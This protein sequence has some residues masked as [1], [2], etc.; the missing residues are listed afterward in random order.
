MTIEAAMS[1][2][3][4]VFSGVTEAHFELIVTRVAQAGIELD[5]HA[6]QRSRAG[7]TIR[8]AFDPVL[9]RLTIQCVGRPFFV[10]CTTITDRIDSLV[11]TVL[12]A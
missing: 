6:G 12:R 5:G 3:P 8:W 4:Q 2:P 10:G 9:E 7:F 1:C 11:G